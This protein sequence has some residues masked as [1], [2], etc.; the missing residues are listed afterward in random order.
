[1]PYVINLRAILKEKNETLYNRLELI[2]ETA[3]ALLTYTASGFPYYT[4]HDFKHSENVEENLNWLIP[5]SLKRELDGYEIFFLILAAWLHDWGMVCKPGE[6]PEIVRETHHIRTEENFNQYYDKIGLDRA[7]AFIVGRISKGHRKVDLRDKEFDKRMFSA[8]I[9][10]DMPFLAAILRLADEVDMTYNR[11]PELIYY[12]LSPKGASEEHFRRH[13]DISGVGIH[14]ESPYK[15][16]FYAIVTDPKGAKTVRTL[17]S[18]IQS[19]INNVKGIL[20]EHGIP[21]EK[22]EATIEPRGFID[23]PIG[24][25]LDTEKVTKILIGEGLY[26]RK[27]VAIRE[28][29]QNSVDAC[30]LRKKIIPSVEPKIRL[31]ID[32]EFLVLEDNGIGMSFDEAYNFLSN[33]GSSYYRTEEFKTIS[34]KLGFDPISMWGLGTLSYFMLADRMSVESKK[35]DLEPCKFSIEDVQSGWRYDHSTMDTSGTKVKLH[36]VDKW[37]E[38]DLEESVLYHVRDVEIP[39][40]LGK[41]TTEPIMSE[42]FLRERFDLSKELKLNNKI[43]LTDYSLRNHYEDNDLKVRLYS[44]KDRK[45][46]MFLSSVTIALFL[47]RGFL[48]NRVSRGSLPSIHIPYGNIVVVDFK[49][50]VVDLFVSRE[51]IRVDTPKFTSFV[52][53]WNEIFVALFEKEFNKVKSDLNKKG[54]WN[55]VMS[56]KTQNELVSEYG[57]NPFDFERRILQEPEKAIP[58]P[59]Y[60]NF[61]RT[62]YN[63]LVLHGKDFLTLTLADISDLNS[64]EIVI[65][66]HSGNLKKGGNDEIILAKEYFSNIM[67]SQ[68]VIFYTDRFYSQIDESFPNYISKMVPLKSEI[69]FTN[70]QLILMNYKFPKITTVLDEF[71]PE[72]SYFTNPPKELKSVVVCIDPYKLKLTETG[73]DKLKEIREKRKFISLFTMIPNFLGRID[74]YNMANQ[75][76]DFIN[77]T[78]T[79]GSNNADLFTVEEKPK[80]A[81]DFEDEFVKYLTAKIKAK[82]PDKVIEV[83]IKNYFSVLTSYFLF[84]RHGLKQM[85]ELRE[86]EIINYFGDSHFLTKL[87]E[88]MGSVGYSILTWSSMTEIPLPAWPYAFVEDKLLGLPDLEAHY[89]RRD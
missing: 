88:R 15:I 69:K 21:I 24:F 44:L 6:N 55:P 42:K 41:D 66:S 32:N 35:E 51:A 80:F 18:K 38:K 75:L 34:E 87:E 46:E 57:L 14:R 27:D 47:N 74:K 29:I 61:L 8:N 22:I 48:I 76:A 20:G 52:D 89:L 78:L 54:E 4:P 13:L 73:I 37:S 12:S 70:I 85:L 3:R 71:L 19:E 49:K 65:Y 79:L 53:K 30:L 56:V 50:D 23:K 64:E 77:E 10:I 62:K 25:R 83:L 31:Y 60:D 9:S 2:E 5:D 59:S 81:F 17:E 33:K 39:I 86:K 82:K 72:G 1:M 28:L 40:Y 43:K 67:P 16:T 84:P 58:S 11:V 26:S 7:E 68:L 63:Y 45:P 36:L